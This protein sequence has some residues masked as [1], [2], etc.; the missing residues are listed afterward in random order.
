MVDGPAAEV[1]DVPWQRAALAW[2]LV[3]LLE[4]VHGILRE[5]FIA[6]VIGDLHARQ[7]GV[8]VGS[9]LV[10]AVAWL[11]SKWL[12]VRSRRALLLVGGL[13]V[14]L[15]LVFELAL[16]RAI[17]ASWDR[18]FADYNPLRGGFM[19]FGLAFMFVAPLLAA[20]L[21]RVN[22]RKVP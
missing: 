9:A 8:V 12:D 15:T 7:A 6:P 3:M 19:M 18:I 11:T 10:F 16:G 13:W 2:M 22:Q 21:R 4:T 14:A 5:L 20:R 17:G 1:V